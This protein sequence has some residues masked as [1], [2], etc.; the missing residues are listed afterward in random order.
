MACAAPAWS[1]RGCTLKGPMQGS[2]FYLDSLDMLIH[3]TC[4]QDYRANKR[5]TIFGFQR[6]L[7]RNKSKTSAS[8]WPR[9]P[10][11]EK[12]M[13]AWGHRP[14]TFIVSRCLET[15]VKHDAQVFDMVSKT[16]HTSLVITGYCFSAL[17]S[18][19]IVCLKIIKMWE[20]C[21]CSL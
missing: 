19:D 16:I 8:V 1:F 20:I 14:S 5:K 12:Q 7:S 21:C 4:C 13:K 9:Y 17:I 11:T 10:D 3:L 6:Y 15:L 18:H 2:L